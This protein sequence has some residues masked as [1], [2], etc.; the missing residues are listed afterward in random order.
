MKGV[1]TKWAQGK[2]SNILL[3][4]FSVTPEKAFIQIASRDFW[5]GKQQPVVLVFM[6][7]GKADKDMHM[8]VR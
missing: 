1:L 7:D 5:E 6:V 3:F 4:Y 2:K 8:C